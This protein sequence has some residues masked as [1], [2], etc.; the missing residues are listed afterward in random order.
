MTVEFLEEA[1]RDLAG[2]I[3]YYNER[4]QGLG[5]KFL[6]EVRRSFN[7]INAF[8]DAWQQL[9]PGFRRCRLRKFPYGILYYRVDADN[10]K[11]VTIADLRRDSEYWRGRLEKF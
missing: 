4:Q 3:A 11:I 2:A 9:A 8:P 1:R 5:G 7:Q 10:I 6:A